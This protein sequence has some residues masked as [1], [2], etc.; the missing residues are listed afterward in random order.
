ML[1]VR[2]FHQITNNPE[3]TLLGPA[4]FEIINSSLNVIC[5]TAFMKIHFKSHHYYYYYAICNNNFCFTRAPH[6]TNFTEM[7]QSQSLP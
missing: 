5:T 3:N 1:L 4:T 6:V 2:W 7:E